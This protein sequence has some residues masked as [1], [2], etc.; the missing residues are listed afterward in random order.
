MEVVGERQV[1][2]IFSVHPIITSKIFSPPLG[3]CK[4]SPK[5][6]EIVLSTGHTGFRTRLVTKKMTFYTAPVGGL[7]L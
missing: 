2:Y 6:K 7:K 5:V 1:P 4:K 3:L